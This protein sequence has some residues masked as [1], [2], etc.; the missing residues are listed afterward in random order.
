MTTIRSY[1]HIYEGLHRVYARSL[2][3]L[4]LGLCATSIFLY[5][6]F[7]KSAA[8]SAAHFGDD[9]A[10]LAALSSEVSELEAQYLTRIETLGREDAGTIGLYE[11]RTAVFVERGSD[12][13]LTVRDGIHAAKSQ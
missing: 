7:L 10:F 5:G 12:T 1:V 6:Y 3:F 13:K 9:Q 8:F 4:L 2:F 11:T